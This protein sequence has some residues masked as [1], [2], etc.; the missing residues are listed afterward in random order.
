MQLEEIKS[1]ADMCK[2]RKW[3]RCLRRGRKLLSALK[4]RT[5]KPQRNMLKI[6]LDGTKCMKRKYALLQRN[7][8]EGET[9]REP[10]IFPRIEVNAGFDIVTL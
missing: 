3:T 9:R 1:C 7:I 5:L 6:G 10:P 4:L 2:D 8:V